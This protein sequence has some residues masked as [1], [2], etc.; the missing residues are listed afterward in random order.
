MKR[1]IKLAPVLMAAFFF[2]LLPLAGARADNIK[3]DYDHDVKFENYHTYSFGNIQTSDPFAK[4]RIKHAVNILLQQRG[5]HEVP[6]GGQ[7]TIFAM[8]N[9]HNQKEVQTMYN[10]MGGGWGMGWGWGGWGMGPGGGLGISDTTTYNRQVG[11]LMIDM[12][13]TSTKQLLWRGIAN[14]DQTNDADKNK[15]N[16]YGDIHR[17]FDRFPVKPQKS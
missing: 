16:L 17:M 13:D 7:V 8:Q 10:G 14:R 9:V 11:R 6:T 12:F 2:L 3:T 5:W 15:R 1:S 4:K